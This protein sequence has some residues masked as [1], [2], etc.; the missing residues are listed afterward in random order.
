MSEPFSLT[1]GDGQ[2]RAVLLRVHGRLDAKTSPELVQRCEEARASGGHLVLN[3]AGVSF[4]SSAGVGALLALAEGG[5]EEGGSL[6]LAP[7]SAAA[8]SVLEVLNLH[9][10]LTID[11]SEEAALAA[12]KAA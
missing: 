9:H 10:F 8:R 11:A 3:L 4:L 5:R 1:P 12:L 2:G 7:V 6:R